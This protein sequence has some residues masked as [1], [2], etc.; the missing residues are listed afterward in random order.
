MNK[1]QVKG[2]A[3]DVAG[4]VQEGAG[5]MVGSDKQQAKGLAKQA[6]GKA[7]KGYGD[8]KQTVK[9][10]AKSRWPLDRRGALPRVTTEIAFNA[11]PALVRAFLR[12][13]AQAFLLLP[14]G[15]L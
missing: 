6:A 12:T 1:D 5:K 3:K 13:I 10:A 11:W 7:Q 14:L 8:A 2:S 15:R 9:D 4:K